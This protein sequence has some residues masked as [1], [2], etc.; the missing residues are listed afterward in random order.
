MWAMDNPS[1]SCIEVDEESATF[2]SCDQTNSLGWCKGSLAQYR[3][4]CELGLID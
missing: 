4:K 3:K 2:P 1:L